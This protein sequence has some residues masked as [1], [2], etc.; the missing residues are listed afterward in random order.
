MKDRR[1]LWREIS[2]R[3][4]LDIGKGEKKGEESSTWVVEESESSRSW[5]YQFRGVRVSWT[6]RSTGGVCAKEQ[7]GTMKYTGRHLFT[8]PIMQEGPRGEKKEREGCAPT[9]RHGKDRGEF[10]Q[11][12]VT[13]RTR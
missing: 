9:L 4:P 13:H 7:T 5:I 2:V 8:R 6:F 3:G 12:A 1:N 11:K 10:L